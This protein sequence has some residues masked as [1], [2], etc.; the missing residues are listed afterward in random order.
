M[1]TEPAD[2]D[3]EVH[4]L[5]NLFPMMND[6]D[7]DSL[8]ESI[9]KNGLREPIV[10]YESKILDGRNRFRALKA[11][12]LPVPTTLFEGEDAVQFVADHN[13]Y[14]RHLKASQKA[15]IAALLSEFPRGRPKTVRASGQDMEPLNDLEA[16]STVSQTQD[17]VAQAFSVSK[18][19]VAAATQLKKKGHPELL[20]HVKDGKISIESAT[21]ISELPKDEQETILQQPPEN[22]RASVR[23]VRSRQK[24]KEKLSPTS[25]A[26][27]SP[28]PAA[29]LAIDLISDD[30][31]RS[32]GEVKASGVTSDS[33]LSDF[34]ALL[35]KI[36]AQV[37]SSGFDSEE[38][39]IRHQHELPGPFSSGDMRAV[40]GGQGVIE[41]II[42]H[43]GKNESH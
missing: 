27:Q 13:L 5:A 40:M 2:V 36:G 41:Q 29:R 35:T 14:R 18:R 8:K 38:W 16:T 25:L 34:Y 31:A 15:A 33:L 9:Q 3:L 1:Q 19:L 42:D 21:M 24:S 17:E 32:P 12:N 11:L 23:E 22:L 4:P 20:N 7:L 43:V 30:P 6:E 39:F 10:I 37:A 28:S 26:N